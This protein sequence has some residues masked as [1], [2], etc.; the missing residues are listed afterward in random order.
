MQLWLSIKETISSMKSWY[1]GFDQTCSPMV[2][3]GCK[4]KVFGFN[5]KNLE[6]LIY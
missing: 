6:L 5:S 3:T 1:S 4:I 2:F